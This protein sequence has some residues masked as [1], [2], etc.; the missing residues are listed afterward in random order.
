MHHFLV[1]T[2]PDNCANLLYRVLGVN[3]HFCLAIKINLL[4]LKNTQISDILSE[5]Y[6]FLGLPHMH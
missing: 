1:Q 5:A 4:Q 3:N 6:I 2:S